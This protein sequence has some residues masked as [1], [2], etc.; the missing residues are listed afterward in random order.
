MASFTPDEIIEL[1][2]YKVKHKD[3]CEWIKQ[4]QE[5]N[6][7]LLAL[8][9]GKNFQELLS[10]VTHIEK[11]DDKFKARKKYSKSIKD[12]NERLL[13]PV[14]NVFT[15]TGGSR[16]FKMSEVQNKKVM[17]ELTYCRGGKSMAKYM[18]TVWRHTYVVDPQ[19]LMFMEVSEDGEKTYPTYK[20]IQNIIYY[21][22]KGQLVDYVI[23]YKGKVEVTGRVLDCYRFVDDLNDFT[24]IG[25]DINSIRISEEMSVGAHN[26][27]VVPAVI[28]SDIEEVGTNTKLSLIDK[29]TEIQEEYLRDKSILTLVKFLNGFKSLIRPR[30]VCPECSGSGKDGSGEDSCS[31]CEGTGFLINRDITDEIVLPIDLNN[32]EQQIP[33][34]ATIATWFG[35]D[36]ETWDQYRDELQVLEI[37][38]YE[39]LWGTHMQNQTNKTA[40]AKFIDTQPVI[41]KLNSISDNV[42]FVEQKL[43]EYLATFYFPTLSVDQPKVIINYGRRFIIDPPEALLDA[44]TT[45]REKGLNSVILDRMYNEYLTAKYKGDEEQ[46]MVSIRKS[47][48]EPYIHYT[49]EQ[50]RSTMNA[51]VALQKI[52]FNEFWKQ[53]TNEEIRNNEVKTLQKQFEQFVSDKNII[54][55]PVEPKPDK[56][57]QEVEGDPTEE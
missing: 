46:L 42:E 6:T 16:E 37:L 34:A 26:F 36:K 17:S 1:V 20:S 12:L 33:N 27:K 31:K 53:L 7:K 54:Q 32:P 13:R 29:V 35:L 43:S 41:N 10:Q 30:I 21:E 48:V 15:A 22:P 3:K 2:K 44:Y 40:T 39:A 23:F 56:E 25:E 38:M 45:A 5:Y 19:G 8:V 49:A 55:E 50:L 14:E 28:N 47:K 57:D 51:Q 9:D 52:L 24:L 11:S 18:S 4:A